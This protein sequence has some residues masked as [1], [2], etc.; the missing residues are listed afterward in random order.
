MMGFKELAARDITNTFLN[1]DEFGELH[2]IDGRIMT[3][4]IDGM[5]VIERSKKQIEHGR[6]DGIYEKQIL[7]YVSRK[8]FGPLPV[9]GRKLTLDSGNY[10]VV[11]AVDEGG[12]YSITLGVN[13]S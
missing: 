8:D 5:E 3:I 1:P 7:F 4:I 9:I 12:I 11:D 10:R 13:K 6:V 2:K